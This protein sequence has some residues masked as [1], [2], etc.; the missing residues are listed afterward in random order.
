[1]NQERGSQA[2]AAARLR[3][4]PGAHDASAII[5]ALRRQKASKD[6]AED[7][8]IGDGKL[9][10]RGGAAC[11]ITTSPFDGVAKRAP[12]EGSSTSR[13]GFCLTEADNDKP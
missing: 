4:L 9:L 10:R 6:S 3:L 12:A 2:A 13:G 1:M 5:T 7:R 11:S 8:V